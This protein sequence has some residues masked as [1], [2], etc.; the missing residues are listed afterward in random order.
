MCNPRQSRP[1]AAIVKQ[2]GEAEGPQKHQPQ[3]QGQV[4]IGKELPPEG[5]FCRMRLASTHHDFL[6][7]VAIRQHKSAEVFVFVG[8]MDVQRRAT[9]DNHRHCVDA[10]HK[11]FGCTGLDCVIEHDHSLANLVIQLKAMIAKNAGNDLESTLYLLDKEI[12]TILSDVLVVDLNAEKKIIDE[13]NSR[14]RNLSAK[15]AITNGTRST[16]NEFRKQVVRS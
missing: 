7:H 3:V 16:A 4:R 8:D 10:P 14:T 2:L 15:V 13:S 5:A 11:C 9:K 6:Q 12:K 1:S